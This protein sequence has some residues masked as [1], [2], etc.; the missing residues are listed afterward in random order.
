M[1]FPNLPISS[2]TAAMSARTFA[3]GNGGGDGGRGCGGGEAVERMAAAA[4][5]AAVVEM[6]V[7][8]GRGGMPSLLPFN[9]EGLSL[10]L[11]HI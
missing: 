11:I 2:A 8:G 10:S 5:M 4:E 3:R 1:N 7:D 6:L 9:H